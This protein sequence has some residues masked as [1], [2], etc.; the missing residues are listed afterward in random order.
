MPDERKPPIGPYSENE[1]AC[2][3]YDPR[4]VEVALLLADLIQSRARVTVEHIGSTSVEGCKGKGIIDL[5]VHYPEGLLEE[6]KAALDRL[7]FQRQRSRD[8]FPEDRPMRVG[9]IEYDGDTFR[10]HAHA[11]AHSS[12]EVQELRSFRDRLRLDAA[13]REAYVAR[14]REI[15][16]AGVTDPVDYSLGGTNHY[17]TKATR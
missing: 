1:A 12:P 17:W 6:A 14:K 9:S 16:S 15:I 7:G 2:L 10:I 4:F 5:M 3:D 8:P 11:I 13:L